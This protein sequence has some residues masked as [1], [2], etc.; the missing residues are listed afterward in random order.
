MLECRKYT[1][2]EL[3]ELF[4]TKDNQGIKRRL[5]RWDVQYKATG[6]GAAAT[7]DIQKI[8]KPF[9]MHCMLDLGFS[10]NT[11]FEKLALFLYYLF[12]DDGFDGLPCEMME[13]RI[14]ADDLVLT[15]QTID[16]YLDKLGGKDLLLR[17]SGNYH[18]Y[19]AK[20]G[21]LIDTTQ[22]EYRQAWKE[23]WQ[24]RTDG[25]SSQEAIFQMCQKYGGVARK[26]AIILLNGIYGKELDDL[27]AM[28]C[29][30]I[31]QMGNAAL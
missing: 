8:T 16:K 18:Y 11:N 21:N 30:R 27:N 2:S 5:D 24:A 13:A 29:E 7:F 15:R 9:E 22:K 26:Q 4:H 19:F 17:D 28:V 1:Y 25:H 12:N 20:K 6:R 23:Y 10:S 14:N 3:S 31:E